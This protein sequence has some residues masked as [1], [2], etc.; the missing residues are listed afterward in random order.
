MKE[1]ARKKNFDD[2]VGQL[3]K[4]H[5]VGTPPTTTPRALNPQHF[6]LSP[7]NTIESVLMVHV[8]TVPWFVTP[9]KR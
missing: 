2:V 7:K 5:E 6:S 9:A 1:E 4:K 8:P 3:L